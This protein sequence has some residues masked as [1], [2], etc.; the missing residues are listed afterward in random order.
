M[1]TS[2]W[3]TIYLQPFFGHANTCGDHLPDLTELHRPLSP[4]D[5][6]GYWGFPREPVSLEAG[7]ASNAQVCQ[8]HPHARFFSFG[9]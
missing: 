8:L 1:T 2:S 5:P 3:Y 9:S 7:A 6:D 4:V